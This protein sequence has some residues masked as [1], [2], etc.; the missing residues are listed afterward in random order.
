MY[1][2]IIFL[3]VLLGPFTIVA[4]NVNALTRNGRRGLNTKCA[5][6]ALL[7]GLSVVAGYGLSSLFDRA[8]DFVRFYILSGSA[9]MSFLSAVIA[10][11]GMYEMRRRPGRWSR[12]WKRA[13][14]SF[15]LGNLNLCT[16]GFY[17]YLST[18]PGLFER[19]ER[20]VF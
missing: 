14:W 4:L 15:W 1:N 6:A 7:Y 19:I 16:V 2:F 8:N 20:A 12:G 17:F 13:I 3:I 5:V 9:A 11:W 10:L 18:H